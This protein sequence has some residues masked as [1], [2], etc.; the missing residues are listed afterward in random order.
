MSLFDVIRYPISDHPTKEQLDAL[1]TELFNKWCYDN[2]Y[3][4]YTTTQMSNYLQY[5]ATD[6]GV[7]ALRK[8]IRDCDEP[9]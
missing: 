2:Y 1:P 3:K 7:Y 4:V 5:F 8:L 9:I 6:K